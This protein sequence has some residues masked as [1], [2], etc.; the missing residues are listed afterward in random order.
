MGSTGALTGQAGGS[1]GPPLVLGNCV[2]PP[3]VRSHMPTRVGLIAAIVLIVLAG[4][5]LAAWL[6]L[7]NLSEHALRSQADALD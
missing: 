3:D 4:L 7:R 2:A 1:G 5:P 6:D